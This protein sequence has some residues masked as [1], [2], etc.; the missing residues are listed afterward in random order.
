MSPEKSSK[1]QRKQMFWSQ[2]SLRLRVFFSALAA[3]L[4]VVV[5]ILLTV[6]FS[7][8]AAKKEE[9]GQAMQRTA[10]QAMAIISTRLNMQ[11]QNLGALAVSNDLNR[12]VS[13][14]DSD[15]KDQP[16]GN[17]SQSDI[18]K[19][20]SEYLTRNPVFKDIVLTD[21]TGAPAASAGGTFTSSLK[22]EAWW[23][24]A[25]KDGQGAAYRGGITTEDAGK[26]FTMVIAEP[27][28]DR[29]G[30][31]TGVLRA[32]VDLTAALSGLKDLAFGKSGQIL[33]IDKE[34]VVVYA[35]EDD[36]IAK[37]APAAVLESLGTEK[38]A[39]GQ[40]KN[41]AGNEAMVAHAQATDEN[42]AAWQVVLTKDVSEINQEI[43]VLLTPGIILAVVLAILSALFISLMTASF[44][45]LM[46]VA[47]TR[48]AGIIKG[49]DLQEQ[50]KGLISKHN[51]EVL[52]ARED[53]V[54]KVSKAQLE[55]V[56]YLQEIRDFI[57][58]V[59]GGNLAVKFETRG[60]ND[61]LGV[62]CKQ[63]V[64]SLRGTIKVAADSSANLSNSAAQL[65]SGANQAGEATRQIAT[66]IQQ[67]AKGASQ[68]SESVSRTASLVEN[69][70]QAINGVAKG[71]QEQAAAASKTQDVATQISNVL[72]GVSANT[73]KVTENSHQ[74]MTLAHEGSK[75]VQETISGMD[76]IRQKV[77][78]STSRVREMGTR[79]EQI[80]LIVETIQDIAS[81]TNLLA[82][83]AAIEAAR[84]GEHGKGFAVV[85]DEVRKL[86]ERSAAATKE[87]GGLIGGIQ[88][89]IGEAVTAMDE[90]VIEV[91]NGVKRSNQS[92][93]SLKAIEEAAETVTTTAED[94][95]KAVAKM[96][97][98]AN[99]LMASVETVSAV[100]EENTAAT[101]EMAAGSN[102]ITMAIESIAS[103]SEENSAAVE[104]VSASTEEMSAQVQEISHTVAMLAEMATQ[105]Q[106][107]T[108]KFT[109]DDTEGKIT[110]GAALMVRMNFVKDKYGAAAFD[111]V[112]RRIDP[113]V[114][115]VLRGN[116]SKDD[117]FP[118]EY[119]NQLMTA[120][121]DEL[122]NGS[123][124]IQRPLSAATSEYDLKELFTHYN[125]VGDPSYG[126][127]KVA[128]LMRYHWGDFP[129]EVTRL[130]QQHY[131]VRMGW[132]TDRINE[133]MC[134]YSFF[135]FLEGI[136][137]AG[138]GKPQVEK[139]AC[140]HKNSKHCDYIVR[141]T[142]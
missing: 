35:T 127:E 41:A 17:I 134:K 123:D 118:R 12:L 81:Q 103:V 131:R 15:E 20:F 13:E 18:S 125:K 126:L 87:I 135:G 108:N 53:E 62:A 36:L 129:I 94:T 130:G 50:E 37:A 112:I 2:W 39:Y 46:M 22:S 49:D 83:N 10:E 61:M 120:I 142:M 52:A 96:A 85:A 119:A 48:I 45:T 74:M 117:T 9:T 116:M 29:Q 98:A 79:S 105:L 71:A 136:I 55:L 70:A 109:L 38:N 73:T 23:Q 101:E 107:V 32:T 58:K 114:Q 86:A 128:L 90:S 19:I 111:R 92:G 67:V 102:E 47:T 14:D 31:T 139:T 138:G 140:I 26:S 82:L 89:T 78:I 42:S 60:Q 84:A 7:T 59:A 68:Q 5:I 24:E 64:E 1:S 80:G 115:Q 97:V 77:G 4:V 57:E 122:S 106:L 110:R 124:E 6:F 72:E 33:L 133:A 100:I 63:M 91:E 132:T 21:K 25:Y 16:A 113:K 28:K 11:E 3:S 8:S 56:S 43:L 137:I 51:I 54:G 99:E 95:A 34:E 30:K 66:T 27:V 40:G 93:E 121:K 69:I 104:Q 44:S 88:K 75:A 65:A 76:A 141:W